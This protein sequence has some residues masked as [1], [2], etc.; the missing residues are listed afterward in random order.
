[1]QAAENT[2][3]E[4]YKS[5]RVH[6]TIYYNNIIIIIIINTTEK[7]KLQ[8]QTIKDHVNTLSESYK[9]KAPLRTLTSSRKTQLVNIWQ[10]Y[11]CFSR[12]QKSVKC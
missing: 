11:K 10:F 3:A 4:D 6:V 12:I 5:L 8:I 7:L 1:L 2:I 9:Y